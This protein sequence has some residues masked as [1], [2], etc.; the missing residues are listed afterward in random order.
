MQQQAGPATNLQEVRRRECGDPRHDLVHPLLHL[1]GRNRPS[2][3]AAGPACET[4]S[5]IGRG[6]RVDLVEHRAQ[7]GDRRFVEGGDLGSWVGVR[8]DIGDEP[9]VAGRVLAGQ[10]CRIAHAGKL[11]QGRLDLAEFDAE[12]TQ[13]HLRIEAAKILSIPSAHQ[14]TRSPVR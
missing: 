3:E 12:A 4:E 13:F 11:R 6:R 2:V 10:H 14:R 7:I 9:L 1:R 8:H 5:R